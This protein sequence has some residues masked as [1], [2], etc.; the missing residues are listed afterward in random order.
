MLKLVKAKKYQLTGEISYK[1]VQNFTR[2]AALISGHPAQ[3]SIARDSHPC[4]PILRSTSKYLFYVVL[5]DLFIKFIRVFSGIWQHNVDIRK[6]KF[7]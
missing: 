5:W 4:N 2:M 7:L 1:K 3:K 6:Q